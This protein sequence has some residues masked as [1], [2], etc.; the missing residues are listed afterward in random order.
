M[1]DKILNIVSDCYVIIASLALIV[2]LTSC[3]YE[4]PED[5]AKE[6]SHN[7]WKEL[8]KLDE[9]GYTGFSIW[10]SKENP[11]SIVFSY[12]N[13]PTVVNWK[14]PETLSPEIHIHINIDGQKKEIEIPRNYFITPTNIY[15]ITNFN[16]NTLKDTK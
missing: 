1:K 12:T 3:K 6:I 14:F 15:T 4:K 10:Q 7:I 13:K 5:K 11:S 16:L 2:A 9:L 8:H